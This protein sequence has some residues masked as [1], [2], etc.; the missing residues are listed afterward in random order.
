MIFANR[1]TPVEWVEVKGCFCRG[2]VDNWPW[3]RHLARMMLAQLRQ[4]LTATPFVPFRVHVA[5]QK[6]LDVPHPE[7]V[8]LLPGGTSIAV[9]EGDGSAHFINL[10]HVTRLEVSPKRTRRRVASN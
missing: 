10:V 1:A 3:C 7:W 6:A 9:A 2:A 4:L 8:W 5:E